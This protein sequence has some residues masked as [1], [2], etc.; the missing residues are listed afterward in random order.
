MANGLQ[1]KCPATIDVFIKKMNQHN[2]LKDAFLRRDPSFQALIKIKLN[3]NH[4]LPIL[5]DSS[6]K[7][8]KVNNDVSL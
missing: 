7:F 1:G 8:V 5:K 3:H 6:V 2:K 4:P